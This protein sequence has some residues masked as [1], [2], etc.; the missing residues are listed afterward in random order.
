MISSLPAQQKQHPRQNI[1][2]RQTRS[3]MFSSCECLPWSMSDGRFGKQ[4]S[5]VPAF[6]LGSRFN[7]RFSKDEEGQ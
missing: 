5:P 3:F 1:L 2:C 4:I 6:C 7:R